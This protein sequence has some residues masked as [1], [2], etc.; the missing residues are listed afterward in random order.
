MKRGLLIL[1]IINQ[2]TLELKLL[3]LWLP[4]ICRSWNKPM[5][6]LHQKVNQ[7]GRWQHGGVAVSS[8]ECPYFEFWELCNCLGF[9]KVLLLPPSPKTYL[10]VL[11]GYD[12]L[13]TEVSLSVKVLWWADDLCTPTLLTAGICF[14]LLWSWTGLMQVW[15]IQGCLIMKE[16]GVWTLN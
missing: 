3:F 6:V 1:N 14:S 9:L 7:N 4:I 5:A 16:T 12:Q 11:T 10:L 15:K 8:T 2:T 13:C